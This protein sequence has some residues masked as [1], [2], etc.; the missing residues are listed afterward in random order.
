[1]VQGKKPSLVGKL[2]NTFKRKLSMA[3][4]DGLEGVMSNQEINQVAASVVENNGFSKL[5]FG[6]QL[7]ELKRQK[8]Q[9][10]EAAKLKIERAFGKLLS[11]TIA[12][13]A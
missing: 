10:E 2:E 6:E 7:V 8:K 1:M 12:S 11:T 5:S 4:N 3:K 9:A 13:Q